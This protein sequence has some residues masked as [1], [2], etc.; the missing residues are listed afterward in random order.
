MSQRGLFMP[1]YLRGFLPSLGAGGSLIG[2]SLIV[3]AILSGVI[4]FQG[5]PGGVAGGDGGSVALP[6]TPPAWPA[7]ARRQAAPVARVDGVTAP[8]AARRRG[9]AAPRA[10]RSG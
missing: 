10:A 4:A 1:T 5:W 7:P 3:A 6:G 2:S 9:A 8:A